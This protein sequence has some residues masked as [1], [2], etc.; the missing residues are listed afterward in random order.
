MVG[1]SAQSSARNHKTLSH[2]RTLLV[3]DRTFGADLCSPGS[4][5]NRITHLYLL[6]A[7]LL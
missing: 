4:D 3:Q 1:Q 6:P 7:A 5:I 2:S